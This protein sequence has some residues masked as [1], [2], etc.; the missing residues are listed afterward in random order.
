M[1]VV[2]CF[3]SL[4]ETYM[5]K[6]IKHLPQIEDQRQDILLCLLWASQSYGDFQLSSSYLL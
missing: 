4:F 3:F 6:N 1:C 2:C 5:Y